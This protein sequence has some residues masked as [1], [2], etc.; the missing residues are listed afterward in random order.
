MPLITSKKEKPTSRITPNIIA[1]SPPRFSLSSSPLLSTTSSR[2]P[3][4]LSPRFKRRMI[5]IS[6]D[7]DG[8]NITISE[9]QSFGSDGESGGGDF[10]SGVGGGQREGGYGGGGG[11]G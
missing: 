3:P 9:A 5:R 10:R 1:R 4:I 8:R 7:H 2:L 6:T 11:R